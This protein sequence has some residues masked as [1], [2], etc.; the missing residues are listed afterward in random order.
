MKYKSVAQALEQLEKLAKTNMAYV[1]ALGVMELDAAT[2][3]P[4]GT[5]EASAPLHHSGSN[6]RIA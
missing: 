3:A 4:S 2:S 6:V 5:S 1:H